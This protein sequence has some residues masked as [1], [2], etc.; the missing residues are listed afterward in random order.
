MTSTLLELRRSG[1]GG[2][3]ASAVLGLNP[4]RTPLQVWSEKRGLVVPQEQT[5]PMRWGLALEP[6]IAARYEQDTGRTLWTPEHV[7]HHPEHDWLIGTPDRLVVGERRGVEI[8]TANAFSSHEW[9]KPGTDLVPAH[10]LIQCFVYMAVTGYLVW[11][12]DVLIG[13]S[14]YRV[15]TIG[16]D[17]PLVS[18]LIEKLAAWWQRHMIEGVE[19]AAVAADSEWMVR[20]FPKND[21]TLKPMPAGA[22]GLLTDRKR[23][24]AAEADATELRETAEA[25]L[26]HLIGDGDGF[27]DESGRVTWKAGKDKTTTDWEAV[28]RGM[29]GFVQEADADGHPSPE[30]AELVEKHTTTKPAPR[31]LRVF[32]KDSPR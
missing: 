2:T 20:R 28:A 8:K 25:N 30:F 15:Y 17:G 26:K 21:G 16:W 5:E 23:A 12:L 6:V 18:G 9:G 27:E 22:F 32:E 24:I 31:V 7:Y 1:L 14:D 3:D 19:P 4:W 13:G 10:Y 29:A 11:D